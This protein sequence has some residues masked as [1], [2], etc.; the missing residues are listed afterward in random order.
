MANLYQR[1]SKSCKRLDANR[2][3]EILLQYCYVEIHYETYPD[4]GK[5]FI[6][7]LQCN[8]LNTTKWVSSNIQITRSGLEKRDGEFFVTDFEVLG[9]RM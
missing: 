2:N 6:V 5:L 7:A 9:S 4:T 3:L 8:D 1:C